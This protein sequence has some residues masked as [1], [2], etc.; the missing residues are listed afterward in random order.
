MEQLR[1]LVLI[2]AVIGLA[3]VIQAAWRHRKRAWYAAPAV[4]YLSQLGLFYFVRIMDYPYFFGIPLTPGNL[5]IWS[6]SIHLLAA[7]TIIIKAVLMINGKII[8]DID[9]A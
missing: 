3:A 2:V 6:V 9:N 8:G 1:L 4:I 5:N 7:F